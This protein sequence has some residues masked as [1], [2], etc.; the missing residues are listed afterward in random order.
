M[1]LLT[2]T[3]MPHMSRTGC[4]MQWLL[5]LPVRQYILLPFGFVTPFG[6]ELRFAPVQS[7]GCPKPLFGWAHVEALPLANASDTTPCIRDFHPSVAMRLRWSFSASVR[8]ADG[9]ASGK[10]HT[11]WYPDYQKKIV[12]FWFNQSLQ[13]TFVSWINSRELELNAV[14][15]M[16]DL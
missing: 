12:F 3:N 10:I 15:K 1:W 11:C 14:Q 6:R 8:L 4:I 16:E 7:V 5:V 13:Q 9:D 2:R